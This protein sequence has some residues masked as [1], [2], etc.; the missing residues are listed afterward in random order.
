MIQVDESILNRTDRLGLAYCR[1]NNGEWDEILGPKPAGFDDL[2]R[3]PQ[4]PK[5]PWQKKGPSKA[6]FTWP[7]MRAIELI[8]GEANRDRCL[9]LFMLRKTEKEWFRWYVTERFK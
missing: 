8:I 3:F 6:D 1:L 5:W 4:K 9:W 7:A 2:P